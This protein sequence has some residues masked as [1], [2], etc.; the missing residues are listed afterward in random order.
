MTLIPNVPELMGAN[1]DDRSMRWLAVFR[2]ARLHVVWQ[3]RSLVPLKG[4]IASFLARIDSVYAILRQMIIFIF[5]SHGLA[6]LFFLTGR[7]AR[8]QF[9]KGHSDE[10]GWVVHY[11]LDRSKTHAY[12]SSLYYGLTVLTST[13]FGD[14][15]P[16]TE[17]E[18]GAMCF[19]LFVSAFMYA[20]VSFDRQS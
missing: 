7:E 11:D 5:I 14:F 6:C 3:F 12:V 18:M 9:N 2:L 10:A 13:G 19:G 20:S 17:L 1:M 8:Y 15:T 16:R 4:P